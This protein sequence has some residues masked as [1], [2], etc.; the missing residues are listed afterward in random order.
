MYLFYV[1]EPFVCFYNECGGLKGICFFPRF[2]V[3]LPEFFLRSLNNWHEVGALCL[4]RCTVYSFW[5]IF[6]NSATETECSIRH[7]EEK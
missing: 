6:K 4:N 5:F 7:D 3:C 2:T 1:F